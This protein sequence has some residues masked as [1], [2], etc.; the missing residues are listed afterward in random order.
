[1]KITLDLDSNV[2][3]VPKNFFETITKQNALIERVGGTKI[4]PVELIRKSFEAALS[5]TD[6]YLQ[7]HK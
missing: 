3:T 6:K 1:M 4:E 5:D 2:I 7:T